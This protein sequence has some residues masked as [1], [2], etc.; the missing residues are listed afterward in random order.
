VPV[1]PTVAR[2]GE[3]IAALVARRSVASDMSRGTCPKRQSAARAAGGAGGARGPARARWLL[4]AQ[5]GETLELTGATPEEL[6]ALAVGLAEETAGLG[7][8]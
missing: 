7:S 4:A 6:A 3:G 2:T 5:A 1:V 8:V